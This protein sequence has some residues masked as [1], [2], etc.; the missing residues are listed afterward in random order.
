VGTPLKPPY[1]F[2]HIEKQERRNKM[3]SRAILAVCV[4]LL[5]EAILLTEMS[6]ASSAY[7]G[8]PESGQTP[9]PTP[10]I[11]AGERPATQAT[12]TVQRIKLGHRTFTLYPL[13]KET[14]EHQTSWQEPPPQ[15]QN[16]E[17]SEPS[18]SPPLIAQSSDFG[19]RRVMTET[20]EGTWPISPSRW[21]VR[22]FSDTD[23]GEYLWGRRDCRPYQGGASAWCVGGGADGSLLPC[24]S[25]YPNNITNTVIYGPFDLMPATDAQFQF[26]L[27]LD[28]ESNYHDLFGYAASRDGENFEGHARSGDA[29]HW[30]PIT[31]DLTNV[32]E[33][34]DLTGEPQVWITFVFRSDASINSYEGA[35]I[36][37]MTIWK[38]EAIPSPPPITYSA[39]IT[40]H[41]TITDFK[42]G[43]SDGG[44]IS[45]DV[46]GGEL[47]LASQVTSIGNWTRLPDLPLPLNQ[48]SLV[49]GPDSLFV[50]GGNTTGS[51]KQNRVYYASIGPDGE[52]G[53]W[54]QTSMMSQTLMSHAVLLE[55][56]HLFVIGGTNNDGVQ[57][58]VFIAPL[59]DDGTL[60]NWRST[61]RNLP[62]PRYKHAAVAA[63]GYLFVLGGATSN[64]DVSDI[65]YRAAVNADST[66]G[67]W[68]PLSRTLPY[69][70]EGHTAA[71]VNGYLY[72]IGGWGGIPPRMRDE[73]YKAAID[74]EG[75]L[76]P[77]EPVVSLPQPLWWHATTSV[78]GG[79]LVSGGLNLDH[80]SSALQQ[81]V[82]L[83]TPDADGDIQEWVNLT[84]LPYP[85]AAHAMA[86]T[87]DHVY[88]A[89]GG[90]DNPPALG[91][92]LVAPLYTDSTAVH[93]GNYYHQF[94]LGHNALIKT[95][96]WQETGDQG[97]IRVRYRV[98][99]RGIEEYGPWSD[100]YATSPIM[101]DTV[102]GYL[103]Y[104]IKVER[105]DGDGK[106]VEAIGLTIDRPPNIFNYLP[107]ILK[108]FP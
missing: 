17:A 54:E 19:W 13:P 60:G 51:I 1:Y 63:N 45:H 4:G 12:N 40:L 88:V 9:T 62:Q 21:L 42:R 72:V 8:G 96:Y 38:Y 78:G 44:V 26:S 66:L 55:N 90:Q 20:F 33:L 2:E 80:P 85:I 48:F 75:N 105:G 36:D 23:G 104:Q 74:P 24:F 82:Y 7:A 39:P 57:D 46:S 27:L 97:D 59:Q 95:L 53:N 6:I 77:W 30:S 81:T 56:G 58:S 61:V 76:G 79:L 73:V 99:P 15:P 31:L 16:S 108:D 91:S 5:A 67:N 89:G 28:T 18:P 64:D 87:T 14:I 84:P 94:D 29:T 102:G 98:A 11:E 25:N 32:P 93:Q 10:T 43:R 3:Q 92:V 41:T 69:P 22:D 52:L 70:V 65:I 50:I 71:V 86:A 83:A 106:E 103:A 107:I 35:F 34:G 68:E 37:D 100:Y 47:V 101:V 49:A